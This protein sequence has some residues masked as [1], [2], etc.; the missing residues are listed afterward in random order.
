VGISLNVK[1]VDYEIEHKGFWDYG[2]K[3]WLTEHF[4]DSKGRAKSKIL[5]TSNSLEEVVKKIKELAS[6]SINMEFVKNES[7]QQYQSSFGI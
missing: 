6:Q 3:Y 7:F 1:F 4:Q 2:Y 5:I